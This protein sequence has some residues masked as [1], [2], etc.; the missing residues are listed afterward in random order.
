[1]G[2]PALAGADVEHRHGRR[3][4]DELQGLDGVTVLVAGG[5]RRRP[6]L[7]RDRSL[8][9]G[10]AVRVRL[11]GERLGRGV[12]LRRPA[13]DLRL[14]VGLPLGA[15]L[16]Q[17]ARRLL[18]LLVFGGGGRRRGGRRRRD[19]GRGVRRLVLRGRASHHGS[20]QGNERE[21]VGTAARH[22][23]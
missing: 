18:F 6:R 16:L 13:R 10:L 2:V 7:A 4:A 19:G 23:V 3:A 20:G 8:Q 12:E 22:A 9:G 5:V 21:K 1:L 11:V 14:V 17:L 15:I